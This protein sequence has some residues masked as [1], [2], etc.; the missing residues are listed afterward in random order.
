MPVPGDVDIVIAAELME[1]G[2]AIQRGLVTPDRTTLIA[3]THRVYAVAEKMQPG[4]GRADPAAVE[5]AA[6]AM[7]R[8][9]FAADMQAIA[10]RAGSVISAALF[11]ALAA[12]GALPFPRA[13][14][15]ATVRAAG[16][17]VEASLRA[18]AAGFDAVTAPAAAPAPPAEAPSLPRGG[19]A[20]ERAELDARAARLDAEFPAPARTML[21]H[22][23]ARLVDYQDL[24]YAHE[25]L[26]RVARIAAL[27]DVA[28]GF[29]L[30][31]EAARQVAVAMSYDDVIRVA[32]LKTRG[33]R[34]ERVR[35]EVGAQPEQPVGTTEFFHPRLEEICA[36]LPA[37]LGRAVEASPVLSR[38][39]GAL[40]ARGRRI[41]THTLAGYLPLYLIAGMRPRRRTLLRHAREQ[42]HLAEWLALVEAR[43]REDYALALELL[44]CRRL[45]KGYSDTHAR[46]LG[47]FDKVIGGAGASRRPRRC[48]RLDP[49]AARGGAGGRGWQHARRRA[50]DGRHARDRPDRTQGDRSM[51]LSDFAADLL[52]GRV[53]VIDLT[54]TLSED[55]PTIA[56]PPEFGAC[57]PFR[58]EEMSRYD[59]R[60]PAW[61][62]NNIST[63]ASTPARISTRR[64][65]G[66]PARTCRTT[67]STPC[68]SR[69]FIAPAC[70]IDCSR[71]GAPPTRISC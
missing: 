19:S 65:T 11:G 49:P 27:D 16:V 8:Q 42:A 7:S 15:E 71:A 14:F 38:A 60:G 35:A 25:Y 1:A 59:D 45:V 5:T 62:W 56:L 51:S 68:R 58:I 37:G 70:V 2:R 23:L 29:A 53:R 63:A 44:K 18:F 50:G 47:K 31:T 28:H 48:R 13:A 41:R 54:Q 66:S 36:S 3:S 57:A 9:F 55:F 17:G 10:E 26:D 30:T 52:A 21:R 40:F 22:G 67:P 61:Y 6:R 12:S 33:S 69:N 64:S 20:A 4:D 34:R 24:A 43:A 46:G 32:D 39:V